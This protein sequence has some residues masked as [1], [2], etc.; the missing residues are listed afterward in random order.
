MGGVLDRANSSPDDGAHSE[1]HVGRFFLNI[2]LLNRE[3]LVQETV[4]E[5]IEATIGKDSVLQVPAVPLELLVNEIAC[6]AYTD[7][8]V[9]EQVA[10][11][12][13]VT[14]PEQMGEMG[15]DAHATRHHNQD[16]LLVMLI[17][18]CDVDSKTLL[19]WHQQQLIKARSKVDDQEKYLSSPSSAVTA[20]PPLKSR[21]KGWSLLPSC[22]PLKDSI[23]E[24][25]EEKVEQLRFMSAVTREE[26]LI[27]VADG[28]Q[29]MGGSTRL[30]DCRLL[31]LISDFAEAAMPEILEKQCLQ[32]AGLKVM[33]VAQPVQEQERYFLEATEEAKQRSRMCTGYFGCLR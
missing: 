24:K 31:P 25:V 12:L 28:L 29:T 30:I 18:I 13:E 8:V 15:I 9:A 32:E 10:D 21:S 17:E 1:T 19:S 7:Q 26:L 6:V 11:C 33:V 20:K 27:R 4:H 2:W 16:G 23:E 3:Q 22:Q 5:Q 14:V